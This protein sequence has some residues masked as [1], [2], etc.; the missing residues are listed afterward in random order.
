[1]L[2]RSFLTIAL[3]YLP[4]ESLIRSPVDH[5]GLIAGPAATVSEELG[6]SRSLAS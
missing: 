2:K 6:M 4:R 5:T 1:M 3:T